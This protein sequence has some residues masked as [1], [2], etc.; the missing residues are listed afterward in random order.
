MHPRPLVC[1]KA[2]R[3]FLQPP[4]LWVDLPYRL[5]A[6]CV[7]VSCILSS[8]EEIPVPLLENR[9]DG[10]I[11]PLGSKLSPAPVISEAPA[12]DSPWW[13]PANVYDTAFV[14]TVAMT[15]P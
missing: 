1:T 6:L 4:R 3:G 11:F 13:G 15:C 12:R 7:T 5:I 2:A 10:R 8:A 9:A 14:W